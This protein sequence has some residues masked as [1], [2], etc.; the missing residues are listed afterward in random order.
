MFRK[1]ALEN[2][3]MKW[4]GKAVLLPGIPAW[5]VVSLSVFFLAAFITFIICGSY[6]R[7]V[8]VTGEIVTWPPPVNI[9]SAVQ[10]VIVKQFVIEGQSIK[11]GDPVYQIDVSKTT[12][13]GVV[14]DNRR[15]DTESQLVRV[16]DIISSLEESKKTT[17]ETLEK[18]RAE[19]DAAFSYST[20]IVQRAKEGIKLMKE[21]MENYRIYQARGLINKDQMTNQEALYYQQQGNLLGLTAQ[22]E[23]NALQLINLESQIRIQAADFDNRIYEMEL[24]RYDLQKELVNTDMESEIIVRSLSDGKIDSLSVSTGQ[25]VSNGDSLL[26]IIPEKV[27]NY[28]L[29]LWVP[30]DAMPYINAGDKVNVR[31]EAFPAE[32]FGQFAAIVTLVSKIP[33]STQEMQTYRGAPKGIQG[34]SIP[35]YKVIVSPESQYVSYG[36]KNVSLE[37]GMKAQATMFLEKRKVYQWM[38]SPFYDMKHSATGPVGNK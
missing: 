13:R 12:L 31:Y 1:E 25:M 9:Y 11:V 20:D 33:A 36:G 26:Q 24:R 5:L 28:S 38:L 10:G 17:L 37:N 16:N 23:Q 21:N 6:T 14:S 34:A 3:K 15:K 8:N 27:R 29:V 19:Y 4:R 7:R 32:K 22:S 2:R 18:Q 30:N 35:Y